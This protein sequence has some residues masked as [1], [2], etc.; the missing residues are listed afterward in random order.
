MISLALAALLTQVPSPPTGWTRAEVEARFGPPTF[1]GPL[2]PPWEEGAAM[3]SYSQ[4]VEDVDGICRVH[5]GRG[6]TWL[7]L[8]Y[9]SRAGVLVSA[10]CVSLGDLDTGYD[11]TPDVLKR[12]HRGPPT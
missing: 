2:A 1:S 8:V 10:H 7:A 5:A 11:V 12:L 6:G 4:P 3:A 9:Y